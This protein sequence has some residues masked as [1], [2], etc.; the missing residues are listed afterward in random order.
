MIGNLDPL[1]AAERERIQLTS[2]RALSSG[3][4]S[5]KK[6]VQGHGGQGVFLLPKNIKLAMEDWGRGGMKY[7]IIIVYTELGFFMFCR[8][9]FIS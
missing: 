6:T 2:F 4:K 8:K 9:V 3:V 7:K 1:E 5:A